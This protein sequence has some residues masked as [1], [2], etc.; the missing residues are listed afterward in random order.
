[1]LQSAIEIRSDETAPELTDRLSELGSELILEAL[2]MIEGGTEEGELIARSQDDSQA[3]L[4]PI[5]KREDGLVDWT[6]TA[7]EIYDRLRGFT[8]FPGCYTTLNKRRLE[9]VGAKPIESAVSGE[10]GMIAEVSKESF[11]VWCG[12]GTQLLVWMV[13][14]EGRRSMEVRDFLNGSRLATGTRLG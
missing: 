7:S 12:K 3:S 14:M 9:I 6:M 10:P 13:Q 1:L 5:L 4:A 2:S 8:P 11:T